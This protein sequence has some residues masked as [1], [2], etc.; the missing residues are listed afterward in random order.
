M[1]F[2]FPPMFWKAFIEEP[3]TIEDLAS[4][5]LYAVQAIRNLE[6]NKNQMQ[7]DMF[8]DMMDLTYTTQL[9]NGKIVP[10]LEDGENTRVKY[11]EVNKYHDL[12]LKPRFEKG[13]KQM[14]EMRK[15]LEIVFL[16]SY[17][18]ILTWKE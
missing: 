2:R 15:G 14:Q 17:L 1:D 4:S 3:L 8:V 16:I 13:N 5:D 12:V 11:E 9:S 18:S 7:P 10:I 6:R